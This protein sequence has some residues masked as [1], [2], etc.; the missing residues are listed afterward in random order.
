MPAPEHDDDIADAADLIAVRL[1]SPHA[2]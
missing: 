2:R 1:K